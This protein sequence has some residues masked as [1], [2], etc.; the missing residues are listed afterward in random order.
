MRKYCLQLLSAIVLA[1]PIISP[2]AIP[3]TVH[4]QDERQPSYA[5]WGRLAMKETKAKYPDADIIDYL[6]VGKETSGDTAKEKFKLWLKGKTKE[7]GV[8]VTIEFNN[9]TNEVTAVLFEETDR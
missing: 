3:E 8:Y 9:K 2:S 5:K 4:A 1:F 6:H 7:F